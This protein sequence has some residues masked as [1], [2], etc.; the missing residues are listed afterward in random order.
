MR[1]KCEEA[2]KTIK[3]LKSKPGKT[4]FDYKGAK[5]INVPLGEQ[6][7]NQGIEQCTELL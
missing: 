1:L 5:D 6:K 2:E 4:T 3:D 7:L